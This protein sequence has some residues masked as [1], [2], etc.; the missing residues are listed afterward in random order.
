MVGVIGQQLREGESDTQWVRRLVTSG[1]IVVSLLAPLDAR[2]A[3]AV[4]RDFA[5]RPGYVVRRTSRKHE[6]FEIVAAG[7]D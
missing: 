3:D 6:Q 7:T 5:A 1:A 2:R 4:A